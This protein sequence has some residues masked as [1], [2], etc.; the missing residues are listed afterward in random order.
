VADLSLRQNM[1][2]P[3]DRKLPHFGGLFEAHIG[4][5]S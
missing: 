5:M 2:A 4:T 1:F 3:A